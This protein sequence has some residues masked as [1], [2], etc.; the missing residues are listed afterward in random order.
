[1]KLHGD[2]ANALVHHHDIKLLRDSGG[3]DP[4]IHKLDTIWSGQL[5]VSIVLLF[6]KNK[7][8]RTEEVRRALY[9]KGDSHYTARHDT[10]RQKPACI[11]I[12]RQ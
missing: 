8:V 2:V 6:G 1:M 10:T 9:V 11:H 7:M 12:Y 3:T 4:H 5:Y